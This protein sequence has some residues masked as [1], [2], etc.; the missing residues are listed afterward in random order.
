MSQTK[1][2][3]LI[4][5][6]IKK[7]C[8]QKIRLHKTYL[9]HRLSQMCHKSQA[10]VIQKVL[11]ASKLHTSWNRY[12]YAREMSFQGTLNYHMIF[13]VTICCFY[14]TH[15]SAI[16]GNWIC[17][18]ISFLDN[19]IS[20]FHQFCQE[21]D[22]CHQTSSE[23]SPNVLSSPINYFWIIFLFFITIVATATTNFLVLE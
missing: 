23:K 19:I 21:N 20:Q 4:F 2:F 22:H 6:L 3:H 1:Y 11:F 14:H 7:L 5:R 9:L 17:L 8:M 12:V 18:V 15:T 16:K 13:W 10:K